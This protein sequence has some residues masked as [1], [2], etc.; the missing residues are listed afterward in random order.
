M[1]V[2]EEFLLTDLSRI[3]QLAAFI[4]RCQQAKN[5]GER[6]LRLRI[7]VRGGSVSVAKAWHALLAADVG[8]A[9]VTRLEGHSCLPGYLVWL[10][11][12]GR[13]ITSDA[14]V[15]F[16][17]DVVPYSHEFRIIQQMMMDRIVFTD[18]AENRGYR[19]RTSLRYLL[20]TIIVG[21]KELRELHLCP[22]I[23][24]PP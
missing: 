22:I 13:E 3:G 18:Y 1:R 12:I 14:T 16:G 21:R 19:I 23:E 20:S 5:L 11:G 9:V 7:D 15:W 17:N 10:A 24:A 8:I 6:W 2:K 4:E